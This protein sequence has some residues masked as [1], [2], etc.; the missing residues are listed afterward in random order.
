MKPLTS[1]ALDLLNNS[2]DLGKTVVLATII[3]ADP[4]VSFSVG[5]KIAVDGKI[6]EGQSNVD[7]SM[8][9]GEPMPVLKKAG[10]AH[11][12]NTDME[13]AYKWYNILYEKYESEMSSDYLFK[14]AHSLKGIG[15]YKRSKRLMKLYNRKLAG[16][17]IETNSEL[18]EI[19]LDGLLRMDDRFDIKNITINSKYSEF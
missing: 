17:K 14:Y 10:D 11:Y 6:I 2:I 1:S 13:K 18:N 19:V 8:L 3:S 15:N 7:E 12:F 9:T 5:E 4:S 16:E